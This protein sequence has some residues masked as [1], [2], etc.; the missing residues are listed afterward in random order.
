MNIGK[1]KVIRW[2]RYENFYKEMKYEGTRNKMGDPW[3]EKKIE[4]YKKGWIVEKRKR[5]EKVKNMQR[6][7][8]K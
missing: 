5:K 6:K 3:E 7:R 1:K 2:E 8:E 4:R